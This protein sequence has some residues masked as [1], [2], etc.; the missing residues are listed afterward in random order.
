[1]HED[2][3]SKGKCGFKALQY[4]S[5]NKLTLASPVGVNSEIIDHGVNGFLCSTPQEW[6]QYLEQ[7]IQHSESL[8]PMAEKARQTVIE[9]YSVMSNASTFLS[10]FE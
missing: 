4:M 7:A 10:L 2:A 3:W 8:R 6:L 5:L 1:M 9:H